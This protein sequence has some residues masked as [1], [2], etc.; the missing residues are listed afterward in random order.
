MADL[1]ARAAGIETPR[2]RHTPASLRDVPRTGAGSA[3]FALSMLVWASGQLI[4]DETVLGAWLVFLIGG[5]GASIGLR[6]AVGVSTQSA[7]RWRSQVLSWSLTA[8]LVFVGV[9]ST[10]E[11][12]ARVI[13]VSIGVTVLVV[14]FVDAMA[15]LR[16]AQHRVAELAVIEERQRVAADVHDIVGHALAVTMLHVN[17]ARMS[18]PERPGAAVEALE[19]AER[20]GRSSMTEIRGIVR[21]LRSDDGPSLQSLPDLDDLSTLVQSFSGI[22]RQIDANVEVDTAR[23]SRLASVTAYRLAQE[24]LTNAVKY[25]TGAID[26]SLAVEGDEVAL[27]IVNEI[28]NTS[29]QGGGVGLA[30]ARARVGSVGGTFDAG[31]TGAG[32]WRLQAR[33]PA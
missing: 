21:L 28:G 14:G 23:V 22:G 26:I 11:G 20:N 8:M 3:I 5:V 6:L 17:A 25:G 2:A 24:G 30:A 12:A 27:E 4:Y 9:S 16:T 15:Q 31:P 13:A 10:L 1:D 18:L 33:V 7:P 19:E 29:E 32:R